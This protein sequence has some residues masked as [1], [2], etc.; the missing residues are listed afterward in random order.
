[1]TG[2]DHQ[3]PAYAEQFFRDHR[4]G[5]KRLLALTYEFSP[6]VFE[7]ALAGVLR[8]GV[9]VD[10]VCGKE[11]E[12]S[13]AQARYWRARW[14]G[15]FHPKIVLLL[16]GTEAAVGIGSANLTS[17]GLRENLETWAWCSQRDTAVL[18]GV[19]Q[20]LLQLQEHRILPLQV[21]AEELI[22]SLPKCSSVGVL[23]SLSEPLFAQ[24]CRRLRHPI[25]RIDLI[26]PIHGDPS[27]LVARLAQHTGSR[28]IR[29]FSDSAPPRVK[30]AD[31][32]FRL[33]RP[34]GGDVEEGGRRIA[35]MHAKLFAFC[36]RRYVD[37]FWGSANLSYSA[38]L[39]PAR[40]A[41][42]EVLVHSRLTSAQWSRLR[43]RALPAGHSWEACKPSASAVPPEPERDGPSF[44]LLHAVAAG[45][46]VEL[47]ASASRTVSLEL[48]APDR[49]A[50]RVNV[51]VTFKNCEGM[52]P[53]RAARAL[54]F[55][56]DY[57]PPYLQWREGGRGEWRRLPVNRLTDATAAT[58]ESL[59]QRLFFEFSGRKL[60]TPDST[61]DLDAP[62]E[63]SNLAI[64]E[65]ERDLTACDFQAELDRFVLEWRLLGRELARIYQ[66]HPELLRRN[67]SFIWQSILGESRVSPEKWPKPRLA[68]AR[69]TLFRKWHG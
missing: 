49:G 8:Q 61:Q 42:V 60:P 4:V 57:A 16:A 26:S 68:F 62:E 27:R 20:F 24:V 31:G 1:M 10:V 59:V 64:S 44:L 28:E 2:F 55:A 6:S 48:R 46:R 53:L 66:G 30:K 69:K 33:A 3:L 58:G 22:A 9:Q 54:G 56:R 63:S 29:L 18:G 25:R 47:A 19:R 36:S 5:R 11:C 12:G 35:L 41:N 67:R 32:F 45:D 7:R 14:P 50:P 17:G 51:S 65:E 13:L 15:T 38:W 39:A 21:H 52:I 34:E 43:D 37:V 40:R 23:S